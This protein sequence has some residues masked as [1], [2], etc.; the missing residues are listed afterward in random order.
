[1]APHYHRGAEVDIKLKDGRVFTK[2]ID[3]FVGS[4]LRPLSDEQV[5]EKFRTLA[6]KTISPQAMDSIEAIVATI[7][8]QSSL[9]ELVDLM[10][11][12]PAAGAP[13]AKALEGA[14]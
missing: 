5:V 13:P 10:R 14:A 6:G 9:T 4:H 3:F 12:D 2:V 1:M 7:E 8:R 11:N